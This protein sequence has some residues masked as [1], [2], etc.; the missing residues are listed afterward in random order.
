MV[1]ELR[2]LCSV[3]VLCDTLVLDHHLDGVQFRM[4]ARCVRPVSL[5]EIDIRLCE[6]GLVGQP[7]V[8]AVA[9]VSSN[10]SPFRLVSQDLLLILT[11]AK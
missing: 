9:F 8:P 10:K 4:P 3:H 5:A 7:P 1:P 6:V 2:L 11:M